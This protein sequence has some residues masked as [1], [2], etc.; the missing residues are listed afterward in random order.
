MPENLM[1][2]L[3]KVIRQQRKRSCFVL[4]G[5]CIGIFTAFVMLLALGIEWDEWPV[6]SFVLCTLIAVESSAIAAVFVH[7][8]YFEK[9]TED[10]RGQYLR[11][12]TSDEAD[13]YNFDRAISTKV[14]D[15]RNTDLN[16][17]D[18][19]NVSEML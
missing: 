3:E 8:K 13:M 17:S 9:S 19:G 14:D 10:P 4:C 6:I 12:A 1:S 7:A 16:E 11:L 15:I 2:V 5:G 18:F